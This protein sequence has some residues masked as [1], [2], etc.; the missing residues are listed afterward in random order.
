MKK[1][2]SILLCLLFCGI[3]LFVLSGL[4]IEKYELPDTFDEDCLITDDDVFILDSGNPGINILLLGGV[5]GDEESGIVALK[6][7]RKEF[8]RNERT[9]L[10]GKIY[11][12]PTANKCGYN[13][14][15]RYVPGLPNSDINRNFPHKKG[16]DDCKGPLSQIILAYANDSDL[17]MDFHEGYDFYNKGGVNSI[18]STLTTVGCDVSNRITNYIV[19]E[20]NKDITENYKKF[21][22]ISSDPKSPQYQS[23]FEIKGTLDYYC[24]IN[25]INYILTEITGKKNEITGKHPQP[26][27]LRVKQVKKVVDSMFDYINNNKITKDYQ[28]KKDNKNYKGYYINQVDHECLKC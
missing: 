7:I 16:S 25:D 8:E 24:F 15:S 18:G 1:G 12:I 26:L 9:L 23:G 28:C 17:V 10:T 11:I 27:D 13:E 6:E 5:H 2:Y 22:I 14:F 21:G 3:I 19:D 20:L 4:L